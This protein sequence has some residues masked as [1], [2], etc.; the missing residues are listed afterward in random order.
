M[1]KTYL[2]VIQA[3]D[4]S[5]ASDYSVY[6]SRYRDTEHKLLAR[7]ASEDQVQDLLTERDYAKFRDGKGE[8]R[9]SGQKLAE[10]L[11]VLI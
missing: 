4:M 3:S 1:R 8:F 6:H 10:V 2:I 7:R 5:G 11:Q 9:V